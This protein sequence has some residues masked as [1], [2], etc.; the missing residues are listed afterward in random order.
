MRMPSANLEVKPTAD[1]S[2]KG[3]M[4]R[5]LKLVSAKKYQK[6]KELLLALAEQNGESAS[7]FGILGDVNWH[8]GALDEAIQSF[9]KACAL[10]PKSELASLGLFHTLWESGQTGPALKE[11][12]RFLSLSRSPEYA[13]L[14]GELIPV[15]S[16]KNGHQFRKR[17][18]KKNAGAQ[19]SD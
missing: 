11:M 6:A 12:E 4:N 1:V 2:L 16:S 14:L 15:A 3:R 7:V 8:L 9:A 5:A 18:A 19:Q 17:V 13:K 10:S